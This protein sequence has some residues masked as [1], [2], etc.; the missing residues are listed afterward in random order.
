[1]ARG[2]GGGAGQGIRRLAEG[3]AALW[4]WYH[5]TIDSPCTFLYTRKG[6]ECEYSKPTCG[7]VQLSG[8]W[9]CTPIGPRIG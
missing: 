2:L 9:G 5:S 7:E 6:V 3:T 8:R 1:M 4:V